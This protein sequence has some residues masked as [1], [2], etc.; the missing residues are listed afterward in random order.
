MAQS[1]LLER[2][3]HSAADTLGNSDAV[4]PPGGM[5]SGM[6]SGPSTLSRRW[7]QLPLDADRFREESESHSRTL[8][9][10]DNDDW[11]PEPAPLIRSRS[12]LEAFRLNEAKEKAETEERAEADNGDAQDKRVPAPPAPPAAGLPQTAFVEQPPLRTARNDAV[13]EP[14][15]E[16]TSVPIAS[17][18]AK[19]LKRTSVDTPVA[20]PQPRKDKETRQREKE[21]RQRIREERARAREE[22]MRIR[23]E[24]EARK[25]SRRKR[26]ESQAAKRASVMAAE[27]DENEAEAAEL[28]GPEFEQVPLRE[29]LQAPPTPQYKP[30]SPR[31]EPPLSPPVLSP[32]LEPPLSENTLFSPKLDAPLLSSSMDMRPLQTEITRRVPSPANSGPAMRS[33]RPVRTLFMSDSGGSPHMQLFNYDVTRM[34]INSY[35][36]CR[37]AFFLL[38]RL[39]RWEHPWVTGATAAF[40]LVVWWRGQLVAVCFLAAFFYLATFRFFQPP[41][42]EPVAT[43]DDRGHKRTPSNSSV[44]SL[45]RRPRNTPAEQPSYQHLGDQVLIVT[46]HLANLLERSKN[47]AL[48]RN[49]WATAR[50]LGWILL[51]AIISV[52]TTTWMFVKLPGLLFFLCFFAGAPMVEYGYW[53]VLVD[54]Y[55]DVHNVPRVS[56][57][58]NSVL[59]LVLSGVPTDEEHYRSGLS[60]SLWEREHF[61][62]LRGEGVA[63]SN[64]IV[65]VVDVPEQKSRRRRAPRKVAQHY[66]DAIDVLEDPEL[67]EE[68][69]G[70]LE[71]VGS[72]DH[73]AA[74]E[75]GPEARVQAAPVVPTTRAPAAAPVP[76]V[77]PAPP[78]APASDPFI[79]AAMPPPASF[80]DADAERSQSSYSLRPIDTDVLGPSSSDVPQVQ[81]NGADRAHE[82]APVYMPVDDSPVRH[83]ATFVPLRTPETHGVAHMHAPSSAPQRA[84]SAMARVPQVRRQVSHGELSVPAGF[85]PAQSA[86]LQETL[87]RRRR[88]KDHKTDTLNAVR[89]DGGLFA[90]SSPLLS[91]SPTAS[92]LSPDLG[93]APL[94]AP[95][96]QGSDAGD[97]VQSRQ[98]RI[99]WTDEGGQKQFLASFRRRLGHVVVLPKRVVFVVTYS[100]TKPLTPA[101]GLSPADEMGL[102]KLL[103]GRY[104]YPIIAPATLAN[105]VSAERFG[106]EPTPFE[107]YSVLESTRPETAQILFEVSAREITGLRKTRKTNPVFDNCIEGIEL[108]VGDQNISIPAVVQRDEAFRS[109]VAVSPRRWAI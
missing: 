43:H 12:F 20:A 42:E 73:S 54:A 82:P 97:A 4:P 58:T 63:A 67:F 21:E 95:G 51:F 72:R 76:Q 55:S 46:H 106:G 16:G 49:P 96:R 69:T 108:V 59:E 91:P 107:P 39:W 17:A 94:A 68:P 14:T 87:E 60:R 102:M 50:Y 81:W 90:G 104:H 36:L 5:A 75:L 3:R 29:E 6:H 47:F 53:R 33:E 26:A 34:T 105:M 45:T 89:R 98:S 66:S 93:S 32:A 99:R 35:I 23:E 86:T 8:L 88:V 79:S 28:D 77:A 85:V 56:G 30:P 65:D 31:L 15:D 48:W 52:H 61:R 70:P 64:R 109:I 62:R 44:T 71:T 11:V 2:L 57:P 78:A 40:Y 9:E 80:S 13:A 22:R 38:R 19:A 24:R 92:S 18:T 25:E 1:D 7:S 100:A 37:G 83:E 103:D 10:T 101:P 84:P 74:D 41:L 27:P